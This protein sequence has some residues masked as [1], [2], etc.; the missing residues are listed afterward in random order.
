M[1]GQLTFSFIF[2]YNQASTLRKKKQENKGFILACY[3]RKIENEK[4]TFPW[5]FLYNS[6]YNPGINI[7]IK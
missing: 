6:L 3:K 5:P 2:P 7:K 1:K 4:L